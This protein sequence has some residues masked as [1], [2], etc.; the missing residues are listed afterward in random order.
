MPA[1]VALLLT[2]CART[3]LTDSNVVDATGDIEHVLTTSIRSTPGLPSQLDVTSTVKNVGSEAHQ[4]KLRVCLFLH[5]DFSSNAPG[6][7]VL[8]PLVSC[9][10]VEMTTTLNPGEERTMQESFRVNAVPGTYSLTLRHLLDPE[11]RTTIP[12]TIP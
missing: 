12:F 7:V 3:T 8:E 5:D 11:R 4:V 2:S 6:F 1:L 9:G 10:A